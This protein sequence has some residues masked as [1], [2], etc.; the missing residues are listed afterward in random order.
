MQR[1]VTFV[2]FATALLSAP[3]ILADE[4]PD[5]FR[6]APSESLEQARQNFAETTAR[7]DDVLARGE[8][9]PADLAAVHELTYTLENA[10]ERIDEEYDRLEEQLEE[11]HLAS[12]GAD[13]ERAR[14]LGQRYLE[15]A[16]RFLP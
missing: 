1:F 5:H 8:L 4:R 10:L 16:R 9:T 11:L 2:V 7:I 15:N 13:T 12:E 3:A 6:G 14:E